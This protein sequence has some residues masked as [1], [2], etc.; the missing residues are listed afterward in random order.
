MA[1]GKYHQK[2]VSFESCHKGNVF[3]QHFKATEEIKET[4]IHFS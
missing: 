2:R 1:K 4:H 3:S